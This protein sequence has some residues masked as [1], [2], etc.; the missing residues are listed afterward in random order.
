MLDKCLPIVRCTRWAH[1]YT[2][3]REV[4]AL[5]NALHHC[6]T[7]LVARL[8]ELQTDLRACG[9]LERCL[10]V[11]AEVVSLE[12]AGGVASFAHRC[13]PPSSRGHA[14]RDQRGAQSVQSMGAGG[15]VLCTSRPVWSGARRT[16][17]KEGSECEQTLRKLAHTSESEHTL[18]KASAQMPTIVHKASTHYRKRDSMTKLAHTSESEH[19]LQKASAQMPTIVHKASTHYRKRDSMTSVGVSGF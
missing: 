2:T 12:T 5:T 10:G 1:I 17:A 6:L 8:L 7:R 16:E 13:T 14:F 3:N 19:T 9:F 15:Y 4:G 11:V 18:Q